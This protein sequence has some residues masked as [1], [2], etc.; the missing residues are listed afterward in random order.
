M[1]TITKLQIIKTLTNI[2][3]YPTTSLSLPIP[4][5]EF[6]AIRR[7]TLVVQV[8]PP[9]FRGGNLP[10]FSCCAVASS[11]SSLFLCCM[12]WCRCTSPGLLV[13]PP[14]WREKPYFLPDHLQALLWFLTYQWPLHGSPLS[15]LS[16]ETA[17]KDLASALSLKPWHA[18]PRLISSEPGS[19]SFP[20]QTQWSNQN[21]SEKMFSL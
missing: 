16:I 7:S 17:D 11:S 13:L 9:C 20:L 2:Q 19:N 6:V 14:S 3:G 5:E 21:F 18:P 10:Q 12:H 15:S 8:M 4:S 1:I